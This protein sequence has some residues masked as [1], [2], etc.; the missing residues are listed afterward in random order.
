MSHF[1]RFRIVCIGLYYAVKSRAGRTSVNGRTT[2]LCTL[3]GARLALQGVGTAER[4][5]VGCR[6]GRKRAMELAQLLLVHG[7]A[8]EIG[9]GELIKKEPQRIG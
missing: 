9:R 8:L 2:L 4:L 3:A 5:Q 6:G 1:I 7:N